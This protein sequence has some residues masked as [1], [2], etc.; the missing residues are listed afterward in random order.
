[1]SQED[2]S[3]GADVL[4]GILQTVFTSVPPI[5]SNLPDYS[6]GTSY[7]MFVKWSNLSSNASSAGS[8]INLIWTDTM[9]NSAT[10]SKSVLSRNGT[11]DLAFAMVPVTPFGYF[12]NY[13]YFYAVPAF[14]LA[15]FYFSSLLVLL[16]LF[17]TARV[18]ISTFRMLLNQTSAGRAVTTERFGRNFSLYAGTKEW[19]DMLGKEMIN[20]KIK[21]GK[22]EYTQADACDKVHGLQSNSDTAEPGLIQDSRSGGLLG[23]AGAATP[24]G[25]AEIGATTMIVEKQHSL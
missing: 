13:N 7:S 9:A 24:D 17:P 1:V 12:I 4:S 21:D 3:A 11:S 23:R 22:G 8:I 6:G 15:F 5:P 16:I 19:V 25:S 2:A 14:L 20:I 10:S 18:R